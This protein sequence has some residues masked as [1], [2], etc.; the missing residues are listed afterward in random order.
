MTAT[1][2]R[3]VQKPTP[4]YT[5]SPISHD[6]VVVHRTEGGYA[7]AVTWLCDPRAK[8]SAHLVMRLDGSEV[9][10]LVPLGMKAWHAC[11]FNGRSIGLEIEGFTRNG[12]D[13][14]TARAAA[15]IVAWLCREYGI[16][17]SW[18]K[19]G[20]GRG[21]CQHH[22]LGKAGGGHVDCCGVGSPEWLAFLAMVRAAFDAFGPGALPPFA[23]HGL[24]EAPEPLR[25]DDAEPAA[26]HAGAMRADI[27]DRLSPK[28][29]PTVSGYPAGSVADLQWR[30][31]VAGAAPKLT[32][33][34]FTGP[35]TRAAV[36]AFQSAHG[37]FVDG[38]AGPK[39][40]AALNALATPAPAPS[41]PRLAPAPPDVPAPKPTAS[42][43]APSLWRRA[44]AWFG[45]AA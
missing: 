14:P 4:N 24:P 11:D 23:L 30:L 9:T 39:T 29:H 19:G 33:D 18:A 2:P 35:R 27:G 12:F 21:V 41:K 8:A 37:M 32:V 36:Q 45:L 15:Q 3:V 13:G 17:P 7:G 43:A 22:D 20:A 1:M 42:S 34:G 6:L 28:P 38:I 31:N 25:G 44:L 10:Q 5:R 16:P 26:S 40:W